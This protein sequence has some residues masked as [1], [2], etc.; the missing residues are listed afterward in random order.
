MDVK[1]IIE[2]AGGVPGLMGRLGVARTTILGWRASNKIPA[3]RVAQI[4]H[5]LK[6]PSDELL[7]L[8]TAPRAQ[9]EPQEAV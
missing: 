1:T 3:A 9:P 4:S 8:A 2:L 7:P 6:L 5:E